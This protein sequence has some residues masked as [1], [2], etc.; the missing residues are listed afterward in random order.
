MNN[1]DIRKAWE[2]V[3]VCVCVC[4]SCVCVGEIENAYSLCYIERKNILLC[5]QEMKETLWSAWNTSVLFALFEC[6]QTQGLF[7]ISED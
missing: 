7:N 1:S 4:V 2:R 3:C 5:E 6:I